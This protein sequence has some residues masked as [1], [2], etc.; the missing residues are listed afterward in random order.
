[1]P[2]IFC[3]FHI[4]YLSWGWLASACL[5]QKSNKYTS[6]VG[7]S[8]PQFWQ[9]I[10]DSFPKPS[11]FQSRQSDGWYCHI[12]MQSYGVFYIIF[13]IPKG[14]SLHCLVWRS[15]L[16]EW[17]F[18]VI[19]TPNAESEIHILFWWHLG[20]TRELCISLCLLFPSSKYNESVQS[21]FSSPYLS[22]SA[23]FLI[24]LCLVL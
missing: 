6:H 7:K 3:E 20:I 24:L 14:Y 13:L 22:W 23:H 16:I 15:A 19:Q 18:P 11:G 9:L 1:M 10:C 17:V 8:H 2:G 12:C 5:H 21:R 4:L